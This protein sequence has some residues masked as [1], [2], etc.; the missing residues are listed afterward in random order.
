MNQ[1]IYDETLTIDSASTW[2]D[3]DLY[4]NMYGSS[5]VLTDNHPQSVAT[6]GVPGD[7][8]V[9]GSTVYMKYGDIGSDTDWMSLSEGKTS[10]DCI[11]DLYVT[12]IHG[13]S[14]LNINPSVIVTGDG[15]GT[16]SVF[17][18]N[19]GSSNTL[20]NIL[21]NGLLRIGKEAG[22][23]VDPANDNIFIGDSS[24]EQVTIGFDNTLI[25]HEAGKE[26]GNSLRA[27]T[28][29]GRQ[30]GYLQEGRDNTF[31]GAFAGGAT[32]TFLGGRDGM[33]I[34]AIGRSAGHNLGLGADNNTFLG[35]YAG[36]GPVSPAALTGTD[37]TGIGM[38]ALQVI[39]TGR[40]N[41]ALGSAAGSKITTGRENT[42]IGYQSGGA[43]AIA[44]TSHSNT[45]L[46]FEALG[47]LASSAGG[48]NIAI[49][50]SA[51][52]SITRGSRNIVI[53]NDA[54]STNLNTPASEDNIVIGSGV[55]VVS[56]TDT[57]KFILGTSTSNKYL[58]SG[59]FGT[60]SECKLG[61][62]IS[63]V[64]PTATLEIRG[65][66]TS[67]N[68]VFKINDGSTN[69]LVNILDN[70]LLR[71]GKNAGTAVTTT[72][73]GS[74]FIG[75][76]AGSKI[77]TQTDNT[78]IGFHSGLNL[79][80]STGSNTFVG[81]NS[82]I[83]SLSGSSNVFMGHNTGGDVAGDNNVVIGAESAYKF[84][85]GTYTGSS[86]ILIG[87]G[88]IPDEAIAYN[89]YVGSGPTSRCLL[90]GD[91]FTAN[92]TKLGINLNG[93]IPTATLEIHSAGTTSATDA[94]H[95]GDALN[96]STLFHIQDDGWVGIGT[97]TPT[98]NLVIYT[99]DNAGNGIVIN[100]DSNLS[101]TYSSL[102]LNVDGAGTNRGGNIF[103]GSD[104]YAGNGGTFTDPDGYL[105]NTLT[106]TTGGTNRGSVNIGTRDDGKP[107]RLFSGQGAGS[108]ALDDGNLGMIIS[109][110]TSG[111]PVRIIMPNLPT[112]AAGLPSGALWNNGG[113]INI[114]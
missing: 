98:R 22:A 106:I 101:D 85:S 24:G 96:A 103:Y 69:P 90:T 34:T 23:V 97:D 65:G 36:T 51:G 30:S 25:G 44:T 32:T 20:F 54:G 28:F 41:V 45:A 31:I 19:D 72:E 4:P 111:N 26:G 79:S 59:D 86:N 40:D 74:I 114:V 80:A 78:L 33:N 87:V 81:Y 105:A 64:T 91:Y 8:I 50:K 63:N 67:T 17:K 68:E 38:G 52:S 73:T 49:G 61:I 76:S 55:D 93:N 94:L 110:T 53:G 2:P 100:S 108:G 11:T 70:G 89:L 84:G 39:S 1:V 15:T 88:M 29:I 60:A 37:N 82:G 12:N 109:G 71:L 3:M 14:P 92:G 77:T 6:Y 27:E 21:E 66:G 16:D 10:G 43:A 83:N 5:V 62:N 47:N 9:T 102:T 35:A 18:I 99:D 57:H 13:C 113:V 42:F 58:L 7:I 75:D 95:I 56:G 112:A 46:G 107:I 48:L 104:T